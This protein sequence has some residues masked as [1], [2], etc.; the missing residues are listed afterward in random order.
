MPKVESP[1]AL[2]HSEARRAQT[3]SLLASCTS[4][5]QPDAFVGDWTNGT[6]LPC[7]CFRYRF[8]YG[9]AHRLQRHRPRL[10]LI[11]SRC[12]AVIRARSRSPQ[13]RLLRVPRL[14]GE[15]EGLDVC[16]ARVHRGREGQLVV[17]VRLL[18]GNEDDDRGRVHALCVRIDRY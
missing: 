3:R 13:L 4:P 5:G 15:R 16:R 14:D 8:G 2:R 6:L 17:E 18:E 7:S 10:E 11:P 12:R 9:H 1:G